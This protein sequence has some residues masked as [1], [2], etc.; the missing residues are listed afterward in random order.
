[1]GTH[2]RGFYNLGRDDGG[3]QSEPDFIRLPN[4][5]DLTVIDKDKVVST[6][7]RKKTR[8]TAKPQ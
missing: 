6:V 3:V 2:T 5:I 4:H 1:M 7:K 8:K